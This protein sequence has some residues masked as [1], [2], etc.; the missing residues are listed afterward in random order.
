[1]RDY[2]NI[3]SSPCDEDCAQVGSEDYYIQAMNECKK[4][5]DQIREVCGPEPENS[6]AKLRVKEF[7]HD[8]GT[9][10]EVVCVYDDEDEIG[11]DYAFF[12]EGNS[13]ENWNEKPN[14]RKWVK[15]L[16]KIE[17]KEILDKAYNNSGNDLIDL[18]LT[19]KYGYYS[20]PR[21]T[22]EQEV[23]KFIEPRLEKG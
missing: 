23:I 17:V 16:S 22:T 10:Y 1:M 6:S 4:F 5:R 12:V 13:P 8:F 9:Y 18:F 11:M 19:D 21:F 7:P 14:S 20:A 2:I 15:S 3:G